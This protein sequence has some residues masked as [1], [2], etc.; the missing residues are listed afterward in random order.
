VDT[1]RSVGSVQSKSV[2]RSI[3]VMLPNNLPTL[4]G[5]AWKHSP[6]LDVYMLSAGSFTPSSAPST[7]PYTLFNSMCL[8]RWTP[9]DV[10][11]VRRGSTVAA[12]VS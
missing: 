10:C 11:V 6:M 2:G 5:S 3:S 7:T 12:P 9:L 1:I 8:R 4:F